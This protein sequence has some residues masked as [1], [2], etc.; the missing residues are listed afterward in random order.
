M[1]G[2]NTQDLEPGTPSTE[3]SYT[4]HSS[5]HFPPHILILSLNM[6]TANEL[7]GSSCGPT[8]VG[9]QPGHLS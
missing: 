1:T 7:C 5:D 8:L 6:L 3:A 2:K 4:R 9:S